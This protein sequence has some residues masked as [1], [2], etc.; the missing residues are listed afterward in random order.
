MEIHDDGTV[1]P[2]SLVGEI[3]I[4][5]L[6]LDAKSRTVF[7]KWILDIMNL[8]ASYGVNDLLEETLGLPHSLPAL[9]SKPPGGNKR[10]KGLAETWAAKKARGEVD[11]ILE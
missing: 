2:L 1:H 10:P 3:L 9:K 5:E 11:V 6:D 8:A 4:D 7:R